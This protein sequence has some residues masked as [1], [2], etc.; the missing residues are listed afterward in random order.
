MMGKSVICFSFALSI[1]YLSVWLS[2]SHFLPAFLSAF[3]AFFFYL[4]LKAFVYVSYCMI[5]SVCLFILFRFHLPCPASE[6]RKIVVVSSCNKLGCL[7]ANQLHSW[8]SQ[9]INWKEASMIGYG[10]PYI[11]IGLDG[12]ISKS[13]ST[14]CVDARGHTC[15]DILYVTHAH[16]LILPYKGRE[17]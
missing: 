16:I 7:I 3:L 17:Q 10:P 4:S 2:P 15:R 8:L 12:I 13:Y 6:P 14:Y 1:S 11:T 9:P 5:V